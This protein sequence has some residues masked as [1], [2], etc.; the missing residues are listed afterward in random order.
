MTTSNS[1]ASPSDGAGE[2]V[3][4][5]VNLPNCKACANAFLSAVGVIIFGVAK[6]IQ[7]VIDQHPFVAEKSFAGSLTGGG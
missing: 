3:A 2:L 7:H 5:S 6:K 1:E 4:I